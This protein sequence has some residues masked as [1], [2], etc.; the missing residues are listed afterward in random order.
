MRCVGCGRGWGVDA[1]VDRH[2]RAHRDLDLAIDADHDAAALGALA[3]VRDVIETDWRPV[4]V[5]LAASGAR[6]VDLHPGRFDLDGNGRQP[7]LDGGFFAYPSGCFVSGC[8]AGECL[9]ADQQLRFREGYERRDVDR[10][11]LALLV[12]L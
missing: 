3:R 11:D 7:D 12:A 4:R 10:H 5:E 6:W 1:L 2:T 9:S 8:I